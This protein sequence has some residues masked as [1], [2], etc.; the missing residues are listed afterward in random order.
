[1]FST[2]IYFAYAAIMLAKKPEVAKA[3]QSPDFGQNVVENIQR[4]YSR[5]QSK[6]T[7]P[8]IEGRRVF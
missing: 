3:L 8:N 1:L 5:G 2:V 4:E 7:K 6:S